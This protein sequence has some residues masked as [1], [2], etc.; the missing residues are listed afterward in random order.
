MT[1]TSHA[2]HSI[3]NHRQLTVFNR[4]FKMITKQHYIDVIMTTMASQVTSLTVVYSTGYSD[5]D[6]R[7]HQSSASLGNSPGPGNSPHKGPATRKMFPFDDVIMNM[8]TLHC[9]VLLS[10]PLFVA[11]MLDFRYL[12]YFTWNFSVFTPVSVSVTGEQMVLDIE[13]LCALCVSCH[14]IVTSRTCALFLAATSIIAHGA[15]W[16]Y[17]DVLMSSMASQITSLA[18]VYSTVYSGAD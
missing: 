17:N 2:H 18:I 10:D 5:A 4:L 12:W 16:H 1:V 13:L 9:S 11:G 7:K 14:S 6:Q 8:N 3:A 15:T